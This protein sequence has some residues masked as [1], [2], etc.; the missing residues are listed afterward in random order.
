MKQ[1]PYCKMY[2]TKCSV[3]STLLFLSSEDN[4]IVPRSSAGAFCFCMVV[5]RFIRII[6]GLYLII[7][8]IV[9]SCLFEWCSSRP[10]GTKG[11]PSPRKYIRCKRVLSFLF[12]SLKVKVYGRS[13][14]LNG[15]GLWMTL[16]CFHGAKLCLFFEITHNKLYK[17]ITK[18]CYI[19]NILV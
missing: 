9:V 2:S 17:L 15:W 16:F 4:D 19:H 7:Y 14:F 6:C 1:F 3:S 5:I 11:L 12:F 10:R 18:R 13:V 8:I